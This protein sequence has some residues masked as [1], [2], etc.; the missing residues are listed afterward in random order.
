ME[1]CI[2]V[3]AGEA[4][5]ERSGV[6][7]VRRFKICHKLV[8]IVAATERHDICTTGKGCYPG[9]FLQLE[10]SVGKQTIG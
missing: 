5:D 4:G 2:W 7:E 1:I 10:T 9:A 6:V 3:F 8:D